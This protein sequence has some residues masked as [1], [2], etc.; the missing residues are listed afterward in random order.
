MNKFVPTT[1][2]LF[3]HIFVG[4]YA[5]TATRAPQNVRQP[6]EWWSKVAELIYKVEVTEV[7]Y[8]FIYLF[9]LIVTFIPY[10]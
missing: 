1:T 9:Q 4:W 6:G 3:A 8:L 7:T 10:T 2:R 5:I